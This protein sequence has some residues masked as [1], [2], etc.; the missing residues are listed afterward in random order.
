M[1]I[2]SGEITYL[3]C[4]HTP[5]VTA[6]QHRAAIDELEDAI[7]SME[8]DNIVADDFNAKAVDWG[9]TKPDCRG[10]ILMD[11]AARQ[12]LVVLNGST[13]TICRKLGC[14]HTIIDESFSSE[15]LSPKIED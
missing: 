3:S 13:T 10:D 11:M 6:D 9:E 14:R 2:R 5:S 4:Y 15:N 1:W 7:G 12:G 8:G